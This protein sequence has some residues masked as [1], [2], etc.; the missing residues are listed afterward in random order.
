[1][2]V[3]VLGVE[4]YWAHITETTLLE[5]QIA[6]VRTERILEEFCNPEQPEESQDRYDGQEPRMFSMA[7]GSINKMYHPPPWDL[8][9]NR[10]SKRQKVDNWQ[11]SPTKEEMATTKE[12]ESAKRVC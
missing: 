11:N 8:N 7:M 1:M 6:N 4:F 5:K 12:L 3:P 2:Y 9:Q 10:N